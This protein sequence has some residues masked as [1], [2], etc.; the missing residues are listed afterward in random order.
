MQ[1]LSLFVYDDLC[2]EDNFKRKFPSINI[3]QSSYAFTHGIL[4][5]NNGKYFFYT[6]KRS[7]KVI[8]GRYYQLK[9]EDNE[10]DDLETMHIMYGFKEVDVTLLKDVE[11]ITTCKFAIK[12]RAR[13]SIFVGCYVPLREN[14]KANVGNVS[15]YLLI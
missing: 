8:F 15:K 13:A 1:I 6:S 10:I 7:S 5:H 3:L 2:L 14:R 11:D 4:R 9:V 12:A